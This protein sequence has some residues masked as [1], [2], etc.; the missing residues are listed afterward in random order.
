MENGVVS[1]WLWLHSWFEAQKLTAVWGLVDDLLM[2]VSQVLQKYEDFFNRKLSKWRISPE[3]MMIFCWRFLILSYKCEPDEGLAGAGGL[4]RGG[5]FLHSIC[6]L[7][8][9]I[10]LLTKWQNDDLY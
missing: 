3:K 7:K 9:T 10:S 5:A 8:M 6:L 1:E 2:T 4:Y